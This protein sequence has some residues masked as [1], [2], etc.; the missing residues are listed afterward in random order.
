[1]QVMCVYGSRIFARQHGA[2]VCARVVTTV[3]SL[4]TCGGRAPL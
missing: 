2:A 3:L 1:M 4:V